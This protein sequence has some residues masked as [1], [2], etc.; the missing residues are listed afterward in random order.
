MLFQKNK[1]TLNIEKLEK[2]NLILGV[3]KELETVNI[4]LLRDL[5]SLSEE[6][7]YTELIKND[8]KEMEF[9]KKCYEINTRTN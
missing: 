4:D 1:R 8:E 7:Y 6:S 3:I 5:N 2:N 9:L